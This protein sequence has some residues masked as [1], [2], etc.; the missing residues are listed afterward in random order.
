MCV[1]QD[2]YVPKI[3]D[4]MQLFPFDGIVYFIILFA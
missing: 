1:Q 2:C 3:L 4:H